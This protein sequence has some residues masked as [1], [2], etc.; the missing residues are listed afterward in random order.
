MK[1]AIL[2]LALIHA[3]PAFSAVPETTIGAADCKVLNPHPIAKESIT[4]SGPCMDGYA[5]GA[6]T[7]AWFADG[8]PGSRYEGTLVRGQRQGEGYSQL[9]DGTQ[10]EGGFF[11]DRRHGKGIE[12]AIDRSRYE[13]EW[14]EDY[15]DGVGT[16][17]Y[18]TGGRYEG[19]WKDGLFHGKGKATYIGGQVYEGEFRE[20]VRADQPA[21]LKGEKTPEYRLKSDTAED[22]KFRST[23]VRGGG[24]PFNKS[25]ANMSPKEQQ[26]VRSRYPMLHPDDE[27]PFPL[28]GIAGMNAML[29]E[30]HQEILI[31]GILK[32]QI[33]VDSNGVPTSVQVFKSPAPAMTTVATILLMREKF[34]PG[35]CAGKPCPMVFPF[36]VDFRPEGERPQ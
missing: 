5:D 32:A 27:P 31:A 9:K 1:P 34:K 30:A 25:Y 22:G 13:G 36:E 14:K 4:W 10:Y 16:K 21:P 6:G 33:L 19:Q 18:A 2:V 12:L 24:I 3:L 15:E 20:G 17:T 23:L 35:L 7:L 29:S 11:Q 26:G 8:K 28:K